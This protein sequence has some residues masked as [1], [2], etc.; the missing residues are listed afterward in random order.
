MWMAIS[1]RVPL[2]IWGEPSAEYTSYY[3][4]DQ[5]EEVDEKRFNRYINL[6]INAEK[7]LRS[8][9]FN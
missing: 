8:V 9:L 3:G 2:L 5:H 6:G 1:W 4:Y 7:S